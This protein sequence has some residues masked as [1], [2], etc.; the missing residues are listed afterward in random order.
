MPAARMYSLGKVVQESGGRD[1]LPTGTKERTLFRGRSMTLS[2]FVALVGFLFPLAYSP[3]PGNAFFASVGASQGLCAAIP[4]LLGY[5]AATFVVTLIIGLGLEAT[6]FPNSWMMRTLSL[7]GGAYVIWIDIRFL[8]EAR[9]NPR[10]DDVPS[11]RGV[12]FVDGAVV[13]LLN[14]KTYLIIGLRFTHFLCPTSNRLGQ[15]HGI[16]TI[17]TLTNLIAF[18]VWT[19]AGVAIASVLKGK[20]AHRYLNLLFGTCLIAVGAWMIVPAI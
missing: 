9:S 16:T 1:L 2:Y 17:F 4:S 15:V 6:L 7:M 18:I 3:G 12:T 8:C 11:P 14:P 10:S 13:L 19:L 20:A 5:H